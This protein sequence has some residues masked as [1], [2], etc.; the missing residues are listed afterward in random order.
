[1]RQADPS[2][3]GG[4]RARGRRGD[5]G[6][7]LS[8]AGRI[9][10][11]PSH[12]RTPDRRVT[13]PVSC[14]HRHVPRLRMRH[15]GG[16]PARVGRRTPVA[17]GPRDR[18]RGCPRGGR[19][20]CRRRVRRR[21]AARRASHAPQAPRRPTVGRSGRVGIPHPSADRWTVGPRVRVDDD[22]ASARR[23]RREGGFVSPS[24]L[25]PGDT[26]SSR[27]RDAR[28]GAARS[29]TIFQGAIPVTRRPL[30][31]FGAPEDCR[32]PACT[33][34]TSIRRGP[35]DPGPP[36][37]SAL[38]QDAAHIAGAVSVPR[39]RPPPRSR[40]LRVRDVD[41]R[42]GTRGEAVRGTRRRARD[43]ALATRGDPA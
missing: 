15:V 24:L 12:G 2:G 28:G 36:L 41:P 4:R 26:T 21:R 13:A 3:A 29:R 20:P 25:I 32:P 27:H 10:W 19:G 22:E 35:A 16:T 42:G 11:R 40:A 5:T 14:T 6:R 8:G 17:G 18:P 38:V 31:S 33:F 37:S 34:H 39:R 43:D 30:G 1:M 7:V 23:A 9:T